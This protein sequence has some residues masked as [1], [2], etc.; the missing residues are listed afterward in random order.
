MPIF[1]WLINMVKHLWLLWPLRMRLNPF[2]SP[3]DPTC[4]PIF[5]AT[6]HLLTDLGQQ[7]WPRDPGRNSACN[8]QRK[9]DPEAPI[10]AWRNWSRLSS[11]DDLGLDFHLTRFYMFLLGH[12]TVCTCNSNLISLCLRILKQWQKS[13]RKRRGHQQHKRWSSS[14]VPLIFFGSSRSTVLY[15]NVPIIW[16]LELSK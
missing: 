15:H 13:L 11:Y 2:C 9:A 12:V 8:Q 7:N 10:A 16:D 4:G 3:V 1:T 6:P 5:S 14:A